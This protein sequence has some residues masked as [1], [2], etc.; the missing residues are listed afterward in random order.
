MDALEVLVHDHRMVEQLFRN[1]HAAASDKQRR[2]VVEL[3]VRELSKHAALEEMF[4][5]P[6]AR[7]AFPDGAEEIDEQLEEHRAVKR[8]L[9]ALDR[10]SEGDERT[11][12]LVEQLRQ[13]V[14]EHVREE[15]QQFLPRLREWVSQRELDRLGELLTKAKQTAPT[16]PHPHAPDHPPGL[17]LAAPVAAAYDRFRDRLQQRPRT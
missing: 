9:L 6:L 3:M 16:R 15:E 14:E 13:E 10:L 12:D 4:V 17:T 5:Y 8:T 11:D 1:Y 7:N 2:A